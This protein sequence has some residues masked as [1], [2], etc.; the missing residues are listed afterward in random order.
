MA[1]KPV[2]T[3]LPG[4]CWCGEDH[5]LSDRDVLL[6]QPTVEVFR[7]SPILSVEA[8][9]VLASIQEWWDMGTQLQD[10]AVNEKLRWTADECTWELTIT[11][12][13]HSKR[14]EK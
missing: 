5:E 9:K 8:D 10:G 12:N 6:K 7:L 1:T 11:S 2:R 3:H 13:E 14:V 4:V